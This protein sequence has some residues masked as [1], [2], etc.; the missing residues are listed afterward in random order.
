MTTLKAILIL[1]LLGCLGACATALKSSASSIYRDELF[2]PKHDVLQASEVFRLS[3]PMQHYLRAN[4][5]A[6]AKAHGRAR[7]LYSAL[8]NEMQLKLDYDAE[9]TRTA[10]QAF[11]SRSGNCLS[12]VI[13][14][15]T[16]AKALGLEVNFH[17]VQIEEN[18]LRQDD[19]YFS[20]GHVNVS[21][22]Q[23]PEIVSRS[24]D[25]GRFLIVD[26]MPVKRL[27]KMWPLS[28]R[29]IT[30]MYFNN[31]A[32]EIMTQGNLREAY[33]WAK[34]A[35]EQDA[36]LTP[37]YI[38]LGVIYRR[39][40]QPELSELVLRQVLTKNPNNIPAL[41]NLTA[42]LAELKRTDELALVREQLKQLRPVEPYYF[43][44]EGLSAM[45]SGDYPR[46]RDMFLREVKRQP[47]NHHFHFQLAQ[48][49]LKLGDAKS[50]TASLAKALENSATLQEQGIY[51][52]KLTRLR[53]H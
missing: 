8:F 26:F 44:K 10:A 9:Q 24:H 43:Y 14:T 32:A 42:V 34:A 37:A 22:G 36:T 51:A 20:T 23:S 39:S 6:P 15:A 40:A 53:G 46:A 19:F 48:A 49:Y 52:A 4:L 28:E 47:H 21:I 5:A 41:S 1:G 16:L 18:W 3:E 27:S 29:T 2:G 30:A 33:W 45:K 13:M 35:I 50:A 12:L 31:R 11:D 7:M 25:P 38:T 17:G